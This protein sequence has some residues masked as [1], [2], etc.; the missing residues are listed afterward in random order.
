MPAP[1][2][3]ALLAER[4][5]GSFSTVLCAKQQIRRER[6]G[7]RKDFSP[8][9]LP[10][11]RKSLR[12]SSRTGNC[13]SYR[14]KLPRIFDKTGKVCAITVGQA[15]FVPDICDVREPAAFW[16]RLSR[17]SIDKYFPRCDDVSAFAGTPKALNIKAQGKRPP[18][19][20]G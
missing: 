3:Q 9:A 2:A 10:Y 11:A 12:T 13:Y 19:R 5:D 4:I 17:Q 6:T 16:N 1:R 14:Q 8:R 20:P 7:E 18:R 15:R